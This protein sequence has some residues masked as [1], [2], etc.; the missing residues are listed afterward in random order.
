MGPIW[1]EQIC[2]Q[3]SDPLGFV[4]DG[5]RYEFDNYSAG[6]VV[7]KVDSVSIRKCHST[8]EKNKEADMLNYNYENKTCQLIKNS[9]K[10]IDKGAWLSYSK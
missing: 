10:T 3:S 2:C 4:G 9:G 7:Q 5:G 1:H 8:Y 6:E